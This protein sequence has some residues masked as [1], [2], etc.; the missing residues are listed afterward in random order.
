MLPGEGLLKKT[1][2]VTCKGCGPI[3]SDTPLR[4]LGTQQEVLEDHVKVTDNYKCAT[5]FPEEGAPPRRASEVW[6]GKQ[7]GFL[8]MAHLDVEPTKEVRE[9]FKKHNIVFEHY[10]RGRESESG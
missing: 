2:H 5:C 10:V 7:H 9:F 1:F 4:Y 8:T 6:L 3:G